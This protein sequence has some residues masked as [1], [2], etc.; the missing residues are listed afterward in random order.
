MR[1]DTQT[2]RHT[3]RHAHRRYHRFHRD[4][5][6]SPPGEYDQAIDAVR[7]VCGVSLSQL[8]ISE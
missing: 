8:V 4:A 6:W 3:D 1:A 2:D 7:F 5:L